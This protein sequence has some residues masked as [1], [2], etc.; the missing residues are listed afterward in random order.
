MAAATSDVNEVFSRLFDHRPFLRGEIEFF[1]KEFEEKRGDREVEE[2]FRS[3]ELITEIKEGQIEKI[4]NSSDDNL[5]RTIAD[6]QV[7]LHMCEDTLDTEKKF[8]SEELLAKKRCERRCRLATV[9]QDVQE[10]LQLLQESYDDKEQSMKTQF[11][12]LEKS[13]GYI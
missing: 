4:V 7:A 5:P 8:N 2:L 12:Q 10:K 9:Q 13:A 6:V 1:K 3:L 11:Q